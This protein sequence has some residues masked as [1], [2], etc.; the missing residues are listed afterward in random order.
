VSFEE[1]TYTLPGKDGGETVEVMVDA[2]ASTGEVLDVYTDA[3]QR[4]IGLCARLL[5][6]C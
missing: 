4:G 1:T 3:D 5:R 2:D 6:R